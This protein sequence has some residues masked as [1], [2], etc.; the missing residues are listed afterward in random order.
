MI[1]GISD[2][3]PKV[4]PPYES[5][6]GQ[7][8]RIVTKYLQDHPEELHLKNSDLVEKALAKAFPCQ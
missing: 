1:E 8:F 6:Y 2:A 3:S 4:C 5:T 7:E